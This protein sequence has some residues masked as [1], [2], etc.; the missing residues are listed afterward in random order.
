MPAANTAGEEAACGKD[1]SDYCDLTLLNVD[2]PADFY[3]T[4]GG[5]LNIKVG[6]YQA[7]DYDLYVYSSDASGKQGALVGSSG[8]LPGAHEET[9]IPEAAGF[10]LVKV[11]YFATTGA[12]GYEGSAE[13]VT[14]PRFPPDVDQPP[15]LQGSL[16]SKPDLGFRSHSEPHLAQSP[17]NPDLLVAG[18]KMYNRDP[19]SLKEYEFKIGT[20][21]SFDRGRTWTDLGQLAVCPPSQAPP[22][23]W[24]D[25][26]C[27]PDEDP[28]RGGTAE[29]DVETPPEGAE[30]EVDP[31]GG[32]DFGEEYIVSD[33]WIDF[34]DEGN[35]YAMVLDSPP[36]ES[37]AGWGMTLHRWETPSPEDVK[38]GRT[39]S[40]RLPISKYGGDAE[41][42]LFLD[43]KN[44][45]A[46]NNAGPDGD[47]KPGTMVACWGQNV[48]AAVKQQVVCKRSTDRGET[49]TPGADQQGVPISDVQQLVIGVHVVADRRDAD[50]FHAFW[51][52]YASEIL[53]LPAVYRYA[54][55]VDGGLT[56]TPSTPVTTV[57]TIP[58]TFPQQAFRNLSL[59]IAAAGPDGE[60]YL[61]FA[62]YVPAPS[63]AGD[64]DGMHADIRMV[65]S[66]DGGRSWG[67][68]QTVNQDR[69]AA[70]QFQQYI[71]VTKRGR[72]DVAYFD[73]RHDPQNYF[74]DVYLSRSDDGGR[75]FHDVRVSHDMWD[76]SINPPI[77]DSGA[78][79]GDYQGLVAD[80]ECGAVAFFNDTHLANASSRDPAHDSGLPR[81]PFQQVFAWQVPNT[82]AFAGSGALCRAFR[83]AGDSAG[84]STGARCRAT[85]ALRSVSARRRGRRVGIAFKRNA[86]SSV[87]VDVFQNTV[88]REV[89]GNR[90][91]ARFRD[92]T[93]SF[94]WSG[95]AT[96]R[97][98]P[99]RDGVFTVRFRA[100]DP[101]GGV[102][103]RRLA[104]VRRHGRFA[105]RPAYAARASCGL[106]T[107]YKLG[108]PAFGGRHNRD[109]LVSFRLARTA[110]VGVEI[111][112][113]GKVV[114][115][116]ATAERGGGLTHRLRL[117]AEGLPR[118]D[119]RVRLRAK[120]AGG[121]A[122][123]RTLTVRRI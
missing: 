99:V 61:T 34:D 17:T 64:L 101:D 18:S 108:Y 75:T 46:V 32:G 119:Y 78:F 122:V 40:E 96:K 77:S 86:R 36:F 79:I 70:D 113:G 80:D 41:Q 112:R 26:E 97:R 60:L 115:R 85:N 123:V 76:P 49:W 81:S 56:W 68:K 93:R 1:P 74:I 89:I 66:K 48:Q 42:Q 91:V 31:R 83:G 107:R 105:R 9:T 43:D 71:Q 55:S 52:E 103:T 100:R 88:G 10:Y 116:F 65:T 45:F 12:E 29:E 109:V 95:R 27:Y 7:S 21:V 121:K 19:D 51:L 24:P 120:R 37:G 16:A 11:I 110:R 23:S 62:E 73:R 20:Y 82:P 106:V 118:G 44:T 2:V 6:G 84:G 22:E 8:D 47:G 13:L 38:S 14:R 5:G 67:P 57:S 39:W 63:G 4:R 94:E 28:N 53:G 69:G 15:G 90:L 35:V 3:A 87:D 104:L 114:R 111:L 50:T 92:R 54:R 117:V 25:N 58:R 98:T 30:D 33:V 72:I 102:D 59:P